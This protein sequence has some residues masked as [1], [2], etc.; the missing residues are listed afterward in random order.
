MPHSSDVKAQVQFTLPLPSTV[1][2]SNTTSN[3]TSHAQLK[4]G[5]AGLDLQPRAD[6]R[7]IQVQDQDIC[8]TLASRCGIS[9]TDFNKYNVGDDKFCK[10]LKAKQHACCSAGSMPDFAPPQNADG[11]CFAHKIVDGDTCD[12]LSAEYSLSHELLDEYN[13]KTW[14]W[15]TCKNFLFNLKET[16][17]CLSKGRPPFP[18]N[19]PNA[20]CGPQKLG[21]VDPKDDSGISKMNPCPLNACCNIVSEPLPDLPPGQCPL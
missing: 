14:G 17:I 12:S 18:A 9:R 4:R 16:V 15:N 8:D 5:A 2:A 19:L 11:S 3:A 6:C 1:L 10:G 20:V 13:K 7:T 21:T